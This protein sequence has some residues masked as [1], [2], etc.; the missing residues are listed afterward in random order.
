MT[1]AQ[2]AVRRAG[3]SGS[4]LLALLGMVARAA[5]EASSLEEAGALALHAVCRLTGWPAG[6]MCVPDAEDPRVFVS[7]GIWAVADD[8]DFAPLRRV[9]ALTRFPPGVGLVG[10]VV[11]TRAPVWSAD[12]LTDPNFIR[13]GAGDDLGIASAMALPVPGRDGIAAVL[14]FFSRRPLEP[15]EELLRVMAT[16]G[17]QLSRVA[18]RVQARRE[19]EA[20]ARRLEEIIETSAEAFVAIDADGTITNWN[21]AAEQ[22]FELPRDL[23]LGRPLAETIV[24]PSLRD[25]HRA[26][27]A[28]FLATGKRRVIGQRIEIVAWRPDIG[29][30]PVELAIW[31]RREGDTWSFNAFLHDIRDRRRGEQALREA[32]EQERATA[33]RLRALDQAKDDFVGTVSHELRT[34]LTSLNGYLELLLDGDAGPVPTH[35]HRMLQ[36]M[37]KNANRLRALIEDL[38]LINQMDAGSL[39]LDLEPTNLAGLV[40]RAVQA[41]AGVAKA[42][43]QRIEVHVDPSAGMVTADSAHLERAIRSLLSNGAKFSPEHGVVQVLGRR[44]GD[45]VELAVVDDGVG[46]DQDDLPRVFDRFFRTNQATTGAVQG[47]GLGLTIARRIVEEHGGTI[48]VRSVPGRGSTFTVRL[49]AEPLVP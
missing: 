34:P 11:A 28:R 25:A 35:Q 1:E 18:D 12:V 48:T 41:V 32:Y 27:L 39:Q 5:N 46:I 47:A 16:I 22:M 6:H 29:E 14:E 9:T 23:A 7:S 3:P 20:S 49:P 21:A 37:A 33:E 45:S 26:G 36:T 10:T 19:L 4:A 2:Y 38:L 8:S 24:P 31:A 13:S 42:R 43:G 44:V 17:D 15:D 30:F 40:N